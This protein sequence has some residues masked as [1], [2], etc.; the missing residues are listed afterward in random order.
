M[1]SDLGPMGV[2]ITDILEATIA[3]NRSNKEYD[4][5]RQPAAYAIA[6]YIPHFSTRMRWSHSFSIRVGQDGPVDGP[7]AITT[8]GLAIGITFQP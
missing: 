1:W 7:H 8:F 6:T 3:C 5:G 4:I 2:I